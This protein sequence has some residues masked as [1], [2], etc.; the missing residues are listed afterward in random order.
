MSKNISGSG[1][2]GGSGTITFYNIPLNDPSNLSVANINGQYATINFTPPSGIID[3]YNVY[4]SGSYL[5]TYTGSNSIT[6]SNLLSNSYNI[7]LQ[8]YNSQVASPISSSSVF[9]YANG[10]IF[11]STNILQYFKYNQYDISSV[12][13]PLDNYW[14]N[15]NRYIQNYTPN[16]YRWSNITIYIES[17]NPEFFKLD[18]RY[19]KIGNGSLYLRESAMR[20]HNT[21]ANIDNDEY[22]TNLPTSGFTITMWIRPE[23]DL[24]IATYYSFFKYSSTNNNDNYKCP[25]YSLNS[26]PEN[27][28]FEFGLI[29]INN[30][31]YVYGNVDGH[32][33]YVNR[34]SN[35]TKIFNSINSIQKEQWYHI[36]LTASNNGTYKIYING[37]Y[38]TSYNTSY[39]GA[40]GDTIILNDIGSRPYIENYI[41]NID[42]LITFKRELTSDEIY[43]VYNYG[44]E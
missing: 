38:D 39:F 30:N 3:G 25:L 43:T 7:K 31:F 8:A 4:N 29:L 6:L 17:S 40:N 34:I 28:F 32:Y 10:Y 27:C 13:L 1:F 9:F 23:N 44:V 42:N 2:I 11:D 12:S 5:A 14:G 35:D 24:A 20:L 16:N 18:N 33:N 21:T 15:W 22:F 26:S 41:G 19:Y 36:A 37:V